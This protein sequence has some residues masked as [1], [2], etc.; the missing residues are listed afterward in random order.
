MDILE[1]ILKWLTP[2]DLALLS[3][4]SRTLNFVV[5]NYVGHQ[6]DKYNLKV[7][8]DDFFE[9]NKDILL[10]KEFA[11]KEHLDLNPKP[12]LLMYSTGKHYLGNCQIFAN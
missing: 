6:C 10:P 3:L 8:V 9:Q 7:Q 12:V 4:T 11:L 5:R 2:R 1:K